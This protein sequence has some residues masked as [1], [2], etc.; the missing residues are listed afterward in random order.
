MDKSFCEFLADKGY[1][2][3]EIDE[4]VIRLSVGMELPDEVLKDV[5]EYNRINYNLK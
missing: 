4:T 3:A 5:R 2:E 1:T